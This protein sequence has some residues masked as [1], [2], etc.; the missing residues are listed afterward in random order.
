MSSESGKHILNS[1][2]TYALR[3]MDHWKTVNIKPLNIPAA[4]ARFFAACFSWYCFYKLFGFFKQSLCMILYQILLLIDILF[5]SCSIV[6]FWIVTAYVKG[7]YV[8][9]EVIIQK[10]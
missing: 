6:G 4:A 8:V 2:A 3:Y 7:M 9:Y 5:K 10:W 1:T